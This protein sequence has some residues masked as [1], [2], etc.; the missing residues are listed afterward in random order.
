[1]Q[2]SVAIKSARGINNEESC[3]TSLYCV[4]RRK[5]ASEPLLRTSIVEND[6]NPVWNFSGTADWDGQDDLE[7]SIFDTKDV[8]DKPMG[9]ATLAKNQ[10]QTS[11]EGTLVFETKGTLDVS[12]RP[13]IAI[14]S[15]ENVERTNSVQIDVLWQNELFLWKVPAKSALVL[16]GIDLTFILYFFF[17][18]T[19]LELVSK[20]GVVGIAL[21]AILNFGGF[22]MAN[23]STNL[24]SP[25][26][27]DFAADATVK[28]VVKGA[29]TMQHIL[30]W[31]S[32]SDT[33][34]VLAFLYILSAVS[35]WLSIFSVVCIVANVLFIVPV[36][37]KAREAF[38]N[39]KI[40]PQLK[41]LMALQKEALELIPKY[42][43]LS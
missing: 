23:T 15:G 8:G 26:S 43:D 2:L 19:A 41:K 28:L 34:K 39:S 25:S 4:L 11:F 14:V 36:Q 6:L 22:Q 1:M 5:G 33:V 7:F 12:V 21:G 27:I 9:K 35:G 29:A 37:M 40:E 32:H 38:L 24:I 42:S 16:G 13:D 30:S 3:E 20:L 17:S 31:H 18:P 10:L